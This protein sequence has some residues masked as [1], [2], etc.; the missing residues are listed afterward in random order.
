MD[1]W[2]VW[3]ALISTKPSSL[4][5][6]SDLYI[7]YIYIYLHFTFYILSKETYISTYRLYIFFSV[8]YYYNYNHTQT[9][10]LHHGLCVGTI[11]VSVWMCLWCIWMITARKIYIGKVV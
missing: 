5:I 11:S 10:V 1:D 3:D 9:D 2:N 8:C 6:S 4:H 7:I